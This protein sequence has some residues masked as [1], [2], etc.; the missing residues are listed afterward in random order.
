MLSNRIA[1]FSI[2][3][4]V[5]DRKKIL[6]LFSVLLGLMFLAG[7]TGITVI[8]HSCHHCNDFSVHAG[9]F[10]SPQI[11]EDHCC[12]SAIA[13][14]ASDESK[15]FIGDCCHFK[16]DRFE[17]VNYAPSEKVTVST[18]ADIPS[19]WSLPVLRSLPQETIIP[20][21]IHNK[22]GGRYLITYN[23]QYIS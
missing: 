23:C 8:I 22:H 4:R 17:L 20:V 5:K 18:P 6:S 19:T 11:P 16:V 15:E 9:I 3:A 10:L 21:T 7:S 12:E 1:L 13:Q 14:C 2:F